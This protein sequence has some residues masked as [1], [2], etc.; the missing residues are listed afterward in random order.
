MTRRTIS[1]SGGTRQRTGCGLSGRPSPRRQCHR[2][3]FRSAG[4]ALDPVA[5]RWL[6]DPA[7]VY[8][9]QGRDDEDE[10]AEGM[11]ARQGSRDGWTWRRAQT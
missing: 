3:P 2:P 4:P 11:V 1:R 6:T 7:F 10:D 8:T 5:R 9:F